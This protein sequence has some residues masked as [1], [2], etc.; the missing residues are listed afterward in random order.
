MRALTLLLALLMIVISAG[1]LLAQE[2]TPTPRRF[3]QPGVVELGGTA[4]VSYYTSVSN[5]QTGNTTAYLNIAPTAGYFVAQGIEI[6]MNPAGVS[7]VDNVTSLQMMGFVSYNVTTMRGIAYPF[8]EGQ[9]GYTMVSSG[10]TVG[11]FSWAVRGGVKF[12]V[13]RNGLLTLGAIYNQVT[14]N[15]QGATKRTGQNIF[16]IATGFTVWL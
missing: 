1:N 16:A 10:S 14:L 7:A 4:S 6:G 15:R 5:G 2:V 12:S 11:G 9:G 13:G 8:V 3:A